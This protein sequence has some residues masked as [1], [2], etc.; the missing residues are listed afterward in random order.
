MKRLS[1]SK[2]LISIAAVLALVV[3]LLA[4]ALLPNYSH[5]KSYISELGAFGVPNG[6]I[7]SFAGFLPI[8]LLI[9]I[10][11]F[12]VSPFVTMKGHAR[13][14]YWLLLGIAASY[15]GAAFFRCDLACPAS[16]SER[17]AIHNLLGLM[18]YGAGGIGL[19]MFASSIHNISL[20]RFFR[21]AG[22]MSIFALFLIGTP[23]LEMWRGAFQRVAEIVLFPSL[24]L[25]G[26]RVAS[27]EK[28]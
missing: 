16:G 27:T 18:G 22:A 24:L 17:Q 15:I 11:L 5:T 1:I 12:L 26:F 9:L 2:V 7:V 3:T 25:I 13:V 10:F 28:N 21:V 23:Q 14:G 19:L 4:G 6:E 8:G 20:R